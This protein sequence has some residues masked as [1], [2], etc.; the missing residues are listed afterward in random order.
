VIEQPGVA[1]V[2]AAVA[3]AV[4]CT[5][6]ARLPRCTL[7]AGAAILIASWGPLLLAVWLDPEGVYIGNALG[8]GLLA[9]FGSDLG[10]IVVVLGL[11]LHLKQL[12][13]PRPR[14]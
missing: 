11:L 14:T 7:W 2:I 9:W 8:F 6:H 1:A 13:W 12:L 4:A 10:L 3:G 5:T